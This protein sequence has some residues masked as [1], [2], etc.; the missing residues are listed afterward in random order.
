MEWVD[1]NIGS[2]A[3]MKYPTCLLVGDRAKGTCITIAVA[4]KGQILDSG[5]KMI[6]I[7]KDTS[8]QIIS[9]SVARNGGKVN[10]RDCCIATFCTFFYNNLNNSCMKRVFRI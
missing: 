1:G 9:K 4:D 8:S 5:A 2:L 6:H 10:Y 3:T 7:G